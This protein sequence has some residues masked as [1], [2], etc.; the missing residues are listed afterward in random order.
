VVLLILAAGALAGESQI[1]VDHELADRR[2]GS[3]DERE[4]DDS[5]EGIQLERDLLD[6]AESLRDGVASLLLLGNW[7]HHADRGPEHPEDLGRTHLG[8]WKWMACVLDEDC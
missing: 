1:L 2:V 6:P 7:S 4:G 3:G 8:V 5:G